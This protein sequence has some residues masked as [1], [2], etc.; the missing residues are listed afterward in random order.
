MQFCA[1]SGQMCLLLAP[2]QWMR[3]MRRVGYRNPV[4][5][6]HRYLW[7]RYVPNQNADFGASFRCNAWAIGWH[8]CPL[9]LRNGHKK[10]HHH[11]TCEKLF[12]DWENGHELNSE[13]SNNTNPTNLYSN[14]SVRFSHSDLKAQ[15]REWEH[16]RS[17][18]MQWLHLL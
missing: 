7:N 8:I 3:V 6:W 11:T 12:P 16:P 15:L 17:V 1:G 5:T 2:E 14:T 10:H 4:P 13:S 9:F 18:W